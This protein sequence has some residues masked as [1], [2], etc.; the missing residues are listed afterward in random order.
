MLL[1]EVCP[2]CDAHLVERKG[3][4]GR[5]FIGCSAYPNCKYIKSRFFKKGDAAKS[6][7]ASTAKSP[8]ETTS[9]KKVVSKKVIKKSASKAKTKRTK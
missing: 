7:E 5:P 3:K 2:D 9:I 8:A 4:T 1:K 6:G